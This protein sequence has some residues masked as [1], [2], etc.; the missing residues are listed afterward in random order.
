MDDRHDSDPIRRTPAPP[1]RPQAANRPRFPVALP[2]TR[3]GDRSSSWPDVSPSLN[4]AAAGPVPRHAAPS[5][6]RARTLRHARWWRRPWDAIHC[7]SLWPGSFLRARSAVGKSCWAR[8][9]LASLSRPR[10]PAER[11]QATGRPPQGIRQLQRGNDAPP[12][13][14]AHAQF[15]HAALAWGRSSLRMADG[16]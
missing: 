6:L 8:C 1:G 11:F 15:E 10:S 4:A 12:E 14:V 16:S 7:A 5:A 3:M 2:A 9:R 13:A